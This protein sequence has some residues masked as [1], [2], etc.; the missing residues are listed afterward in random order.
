MV[1]TSQ[2]RK[3]WPSTP[4]RCIGWKVGAS[5]R[6][7]F[8]RCHTSMT[9]SCWSWHW[10]DSRSHT[11]ITVPL[12]LRQIGENRE[13]SNCWKFTEVKWTLIGSFIKEYLTCRYKFCID[14]LTV[15]FSEHFGKS[16]V[17]LLQTVSKCGCI[18]LCAVFC[19]PLCMCCSWSR[20]V[21]SIVSV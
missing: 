10:R 14:W 8:H 7:R 21:T 2:L 11:G 12:V 3:L 6:F 9:R 17:I 18:K 19:G 20:E 5:R 1:R 16:R 15:I 4:R 13:T